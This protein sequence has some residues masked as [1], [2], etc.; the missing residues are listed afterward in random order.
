[1]VCIDFFFPAFSKVVLVANGGRLYNTLNLLATTFSGKVIAQ[2]A[3]WEA[4]CLQTIAI[5][6]RL[7]AITLRQIGEVQKIAV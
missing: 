5:W 6:L 4:A 2:V 3:Y 7:T 1:M